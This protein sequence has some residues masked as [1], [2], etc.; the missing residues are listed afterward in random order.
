MTT[1]TEQL[2][3]KIVEILYGELTYKNYLANPK[4][5][6]TADA[7]IDQVLHAF[8]DIGG[9]FVDR[10]AELPDCG[11]AQMTAARYSTDAYCPLIKA[12]YKKTEEIEE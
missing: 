6:H 11:H 10:D 12:G 3:K 1:K 9:A 7:K 5:R 8:K 4:V 2:R